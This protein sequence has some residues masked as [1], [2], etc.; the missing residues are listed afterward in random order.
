MRPAISPCGIKVRT[1][2]SRDGHSEVKFRDTNFACAGVLEIDPCFA[3]QQQVIAGV[4]VAPDVKELYSDMHTYL[5]G[6]LWSP[7]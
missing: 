2:H 3:W 1:G 6:K 7:R 4:G 5:K